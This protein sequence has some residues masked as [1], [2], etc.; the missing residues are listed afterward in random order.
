[1][2]R[3]NL[4]AQS[5]VNP[6][7]R[8]LCTPPSG[9]AENPC[10]DGLCEETETTVTSQNNYNIQLDVTAVLESGVSSRGSCLDVGPRL[11]GLEEDVRASRWKCVP[12]QV[13]GSV[14]L[15]SPACYDVNSLYLLP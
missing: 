4:S 1:M 6:Q 13:F 14:A 11:W 15:C 10:G 7:L 12:G 5:T 8:Q 9:P 2:A 3:A